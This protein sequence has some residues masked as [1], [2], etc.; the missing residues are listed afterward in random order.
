MH[1]MRGASERYR[2][3]CDELAVVIFDSIEHIDKMARVG[4]AVAKHK[5]SPEHFKGFV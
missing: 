4:Q 3:V 2:G 1:C 5:I